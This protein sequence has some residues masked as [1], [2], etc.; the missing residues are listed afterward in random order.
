MAALLPEDPNLPCDVLTNHAQLID[1]ALSDVNVLSQGQITLT[2]TDGSTFTNTFPFIPDYIIFGIIPSMGTLSPNLNRISW[3]SGSYQ[4]NT[5]FISTGAGFFDLTAGDL[6]NPRVDIIYLDTLGIMHVIIGTPAIQPITPVNPVNTIKVAEIA[7]NVNASG[8]TGGYTLTQ[9]NFAGGGNNVQN[10]NIQGQ[11]L[12]WDTVSLKWKSNNFLKATSSTVNI[13]SSSGPESLNLNGRFYLDPVFAPGTTTN[14]LYNVGGNLFWNGIQLDTAGSLPTGTTLNS[15]LRWNGISWIEDINF[16]IADDANN[17]GAGTT[18]SFGTGTNNLIFGKSIFGNLTTGSR[19][20]VI[21]SNSGGL[22]TTAIDTVIIGY[23]SGT[24]ITSGTN[25]TIIGQ[26][27][28]NSLTIGFNNVIIGDG[29]SLIGLGTA[30]YNV[31]IGS[32]ITGTMTNSSYNTAIG[33][34]INYSGSPSQT[35]AIGTGALV[36]ASNQMIIGSTVSSINDIYIG[37][38]RLNGLASAGFNVR[39]QTSK[40]QGTNLSG[41]NLTIAAQQSTGTGIP[42]NIIFQTS[43]AG[44]SGSSLNTFV[45]KMTIS[46]DTITLNAGQIIKVSDKFIGF[47]ATINEYIYLIDSTLGPITVILPTASIVRGQTWIFKD[48]LGVSGTN[49]IILDPSGAT[50]IDNIS[51]FLM[52]TDNI[53]VQVIYDGTNYHIL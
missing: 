31:F 38:G 1:T 5:Q 17:F 11:T 7:V 24:N 2:R 37:R 12:Y 13:N 25:N 49:N 33:T 27:S 36:T 4:I 32:A 40:Q 9:V 20:L 44:V 52:D 39:L 46:Q 16:R 42:G 26:N 43:D 28:A 21:G 29:N 3:T 6:V 34:N 53:S 19:L 14:K 10:G 15:T 22:M 48:K 45:D 30:A 50:L 35:I 47:T 8:T 41:G 18:L 51:T 23:N